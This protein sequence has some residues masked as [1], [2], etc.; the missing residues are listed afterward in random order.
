MHKIVVMHKNSPN[1]KHALFDEVLGCVLF[2]D[3]RA[4]LLIAVVK[5]PEVVTVLRSQ[6]KVQCR[7]MWSNP[8]N[9]GCRIVATVLGN[10]SLYQE[11]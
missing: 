7:R 11:W 2:V 4:G 10:P 9:H 6:L 8:P 1:R 3:E 5:S